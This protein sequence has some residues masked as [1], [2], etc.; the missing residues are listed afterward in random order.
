[1]NPILHGWTLCILRFMIQ[2]GKKA[3]LRQKWKNPPYRT[4]TSLRKSIRFAY[5]NPERV[6]A[7]LT[8]GGKQSNGTRNVCY[9]EMGWSKAGAGIL[10]IERQGNHRLRI[11]SKK[12]H[13]RLI[14]KHITAKVNRRELILGSEIAMIVSDMKT[15]SLYPECSELRYSYR[16]GYTDL[17]S[18]P[19]PL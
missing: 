2:E 19:I 7:G 4:I 11:L 17:S 13:K 10:F 6:L 18:V 3:Y 12:S 14:R 9:S 15:I 1:M 8:Q 16:S 5:I